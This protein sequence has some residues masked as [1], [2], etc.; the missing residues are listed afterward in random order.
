[1]GDVMTHDERPRWQEEWKSPRTKEEWEALHEQDFRK[2]LE[3]FYAAY[4]KR[5]ETGERA[6]YIKAILALMRGLDRL[7]VLRAL[8]HSRPQDRE[9][10]AFTWHGALVWLVK[11]ASRGTG[12]MAG[13]LSSTL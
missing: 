1:M 5:A 13:F 11:L 8:D 10:A 7:G 3:D 12:L 6:A 4:L 9:T 2:D